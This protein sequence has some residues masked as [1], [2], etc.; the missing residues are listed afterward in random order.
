MEDSTR[1]SVIVL[2][3]LAGVVIALFVVSV[4]YRPDEE[5]PGS[6]GSSSTRER[7]RDRLFPAKPVAPGQLGGCT[8]A[9]GAFTIAGSCELKIA[10]ADARSRRL[11]V[12]ATDP[13]ELRRTMNADG[14][15]MAMRA[16]LGPGKREQIFVGEDGETIGLRCLG[17]LTCRAV[18]R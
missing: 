9:L 11:I 14:R 3:I 1:R 10:A 4:V 2:G 15:R 5:A 6:G 17:G 18:L 16:E 13:V 12:E 7:W 8:A